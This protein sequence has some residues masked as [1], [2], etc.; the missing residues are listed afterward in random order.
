MLLHIDLLGLIYDVSAFSAV[1]PIIISFFRF[2]LFKRDLYSVVLL[3]YFAGFIEIINSF[4]IWEGMGNFYIFRFYTLLEFL[5]LSLFYFRFFN[6]YFKPL[7]LYPLTLL[8]LFVATYDY[9]INGLM[10]LDNLSSSTSSILLSCYALFLFYYLLK[11][12]LI[13]DILSSPIF[14]INS[15]VLVYF[16]GN[17]FLF[18]FSDALFKLDSKSY[19]FFW[20]TIHSFFNISYNVLLAVALW[21][22]KTK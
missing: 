7:I 18:T 21:K 20:G 9:K 5:L 3:V 14:W 6:H 10:T 15:A 8:F 17:L 22:T 11:Y 16:S 4:N 12:L 1:A 13:Q 19:N 2:K